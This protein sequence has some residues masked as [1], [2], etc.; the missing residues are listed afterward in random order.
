MSEVK[1]F[2][3]EEPIEP[4]LW[5]EPIFDTDH[6]YSI[7]FIGDPQYITCGD[8]YLGTHKYHDQLGFVA[9]TAEER[10]LKHLF[11]LGDITDLGYRNDANL[12]S[13][14][15]FPPKTREWEIARDAMF[16]LNGTGVTYSLCRGNHDDY[17]IDDYFNVPEY[18]DQFKGVGGFY[19][20]SEAKHP[21]RREVRNPEGYIY[22]SAI[23]GRH[24]ESIVN[25]YIEK[26][27][28]GV[29][30]L[31]VAVDFNPTEKVLEWVDEL[32]SKYPN[33][34]AI[35]TT[36]SYLKN[37]GGHITTEA[38]GTMFPMPFTANVFWDRVY[39]KHKNIVMIVSGHVGGLQLKTNVIEG[40]NGNKVLEVLCNP[41]VY[42]AK[43]IDFN[44]TIEHGKQDT[45]LVLYMNFS[46]DGKK[47][48]FNYY[49]TLLGKMLK[50]NSYEFE[51]DC[52]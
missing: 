18:T 42:D 10:K 43:E 41:Q 48:R 46:E 28:C 17:M 7:A 15:Y 12:A 31:L 34:R 37:N 4:E 32:L 35:I 27:I 13:Y 23:S 38:G 33:H 39:S 19:S 16:Q 3:Y 6:A 45:G 5:E 22:W 47:V 8:Y 44:G 24:T 25:S 52:Q 9:A 20:D 1:N 50:N 26:E 21:G 49:S 11:V 40:D 2:V 36:H 29:K 51:L 30:Y 14:H